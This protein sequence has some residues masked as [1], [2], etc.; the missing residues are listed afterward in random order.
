MELTIIAIALVILVVIFGLNLAQLSRLADAHQV[1]VF[2]IDTLHDNVK[3]VVGSLVDHHKNPPKTKEQQAHWDEAI[4]NI[5]AR[6]NSPGPGLMQWEDVKAVR[7]R[8][9]H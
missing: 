4:A 1:D 6:L 7:K 8:Y 2:T 9:L 5:E 3:F